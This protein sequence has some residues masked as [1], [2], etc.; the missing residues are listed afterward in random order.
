MVKIVLICGHSEACMYRYRHRG[1]SYKYCLACVLE[2]GNVPE[3]GTKEWQQFCARK[4]PVEIKPK[5]MEE[6]VKEKTETKKSKPKTIKSKSVIK[7][8]A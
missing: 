1:I 5:T 3:M 2:N 4:Q 6:V 7:K 8:E